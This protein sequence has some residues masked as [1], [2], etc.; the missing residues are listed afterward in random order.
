[1]SQR[2]HGRAASHRVAMLEVFFCRFD[3]SIKTCEIVV[4]LN[5]LHY[6]AWSGKGLCHANLSQ[7]LEAIECFDK[8]LALNPHLSQVKRYMRVLQAGNKLK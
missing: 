8:A 6:S 2:W 1:M 5:P 7:N 3:D 4:D